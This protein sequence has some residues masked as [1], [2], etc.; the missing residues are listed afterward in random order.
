MVMRVSSMTI[1]AAAL[2]LV[3]C[4]AS[5]KPDLVNP[6][7][8]VFLNAAV[9]AVEEQRSG[10]EAVAIKAG[11]IIYVG[12]DEGAAPYIGAD[13]EVMDLA[14][15]MLLPGFH[16]SHIH[17]LIGVFADEEC[18]LR[19]LGTAEEVAIRLQGCTELGGIGDDGWILGSAGDRYS[20]AG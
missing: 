10:V 4:G 15:Q 19:R 7:D 16:D 3:A 18:D 6:A 11:K 20:D 8:R 13:S 12:D 1:L 17:I 9:Y 14:G 5:D 2:G